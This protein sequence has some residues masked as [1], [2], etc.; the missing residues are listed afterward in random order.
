MTVE[1]PD[2]HRDVHGPLFAAHQRRHAGTDWFSRRRPAR[3]PRPGTGSRSRADTEGRG[4]TRPR[5]R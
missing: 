2:C 5:Y 3:S 1:C 4:R